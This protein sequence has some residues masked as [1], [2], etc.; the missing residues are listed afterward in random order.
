M[1]NLYM[2]TENTLHKGSQGI[3]QVS[4]SMFGNDYIRR[5]SPFPLTIEHIA[6]YT[7]DTDYRNEDGESFFSSEEKALEY[8]GHRLRVRIGE[9]EKSIHRDLD[10]LAT[11]WGREN[12]RNR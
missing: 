7:V 6:G 8:I 12:D 1:R 3:K 11:I 4:V 9:M 2:V 5:I 10:A